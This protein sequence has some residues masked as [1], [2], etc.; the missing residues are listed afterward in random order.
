M[1]RGLLLLSLCCLPFISPAQYWEQHWIDSNYEFTGSGGA[2]V[3]V[4]QTECEEAF[5]QVT[6]PVNAPLPAFSPLIIN[7]QEIKF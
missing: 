1:I 7:P 4:T 6:D 2:A 5:L 3:T